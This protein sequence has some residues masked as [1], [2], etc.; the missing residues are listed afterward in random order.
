MGVE[1]DLITVEKAANLMVKGIPL[2]ELI[3][4]NQLL[5]GRP[6]EE[7]RHV[8]EQIDLEER[9]NQLMQSRLK[10]ETN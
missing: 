5:G 3:K 4:S 7:I 6:T 8:I 10:D 9:A 2:S 1:K